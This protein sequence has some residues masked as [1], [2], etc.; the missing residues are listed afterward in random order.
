MAPVLYQN[1]PPIRLASSGG[2]GSF[3]YANTSVFGARGVRA[4]D[5]SARQ[6]LSVGDPPQIVIPGGGGGARAFRSMPFGSHAPGFN[7]NGIVVIRLTR[8]E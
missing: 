4:V 8:I 5:P 6:S 7:P 2:R 1:V 3:S